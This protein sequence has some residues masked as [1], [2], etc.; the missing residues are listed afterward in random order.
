MAAVA[1]A[2]PAKRALR[3]DPMRALHYE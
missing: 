2:L 3:I 1:V